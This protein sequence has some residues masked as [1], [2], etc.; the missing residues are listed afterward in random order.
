MRKKGTRNPRRRLT[1][2]ERDDARDLAAM[3]RVEAQGGR[4]Y[5]FEQVARKFGL[6]DLADKHKQR[7]LAATR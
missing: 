3:R 2:E 6:Y 4:M 7:R 1:P 5:T